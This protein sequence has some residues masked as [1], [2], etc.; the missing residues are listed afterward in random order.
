VRASAC[1][2]RYFLDLSRRLRMLG[3]AVARAFDSRCDR[4]IRG[5]MRLI[6]SLELQVADDDSQSPRARS[7]RATRKNGRS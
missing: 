1:E 4:L 5:L 3:E 7:H 6:E 2:V